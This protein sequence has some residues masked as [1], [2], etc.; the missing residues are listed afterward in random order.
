MPA[1]Y[2]DILGVSRN[3]T[4]KEIRSAFLRLAREFHPDKQ[5][6]RKPGKKIT[7]DEFKGV[8]D[9][10]ETLHDPSK[11]FMYDVLGNTSPVLTDPEDLRVVQT[12]C[13]CCCCFTGFYLILALL[14]WTHVLNVSWFILF[15]PA[16]LFDGLVLLPLCY[17]VLSSR[18]DTWHDYVPLLD[19]LAF[20]A[21][22]VLLYTQLTGYTHSWVMAAGPWILIRTAHSLGITRLPTVEHTKLFQSGASLPGVW[23]Y[24]E[25]FVKATWLPGFLLASAMMLDGK[26]P[27]AEW[28]QIWLVPWVRWA[29][30]W[31]AAGALVGGGGGAKDAGCGGF[32][33]STG[34]FGAWVSLY[35]CFAGPF[36][37]HVA[38]LSLIA[39]MSLST[40][41]QPSHRRDYTEVPQAGPTPPGGSAARSS[42]AMPS[43]AR[44]GQQYSAAAARSQSMV[45]RASSEE[46]IEYV[47]LDMPY[48]RP[49]PA[50]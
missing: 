12:A 49:S 35:F 26:L 4:Q 13:C 48:P 27:G 23:G 28:W 47:S 7:G 43:P 5:I 42:T 8:R 30:L 17:A 37:W 50:T 3:A 38:L 21:T 22:T 2:Y 32:C 39:F 1:D 15:I 14:R 18:V 10:Y 29:V 45:S 11:R 44:P 20:I 6:A 9:A 24:V 19:M 46:R 36:S 34:Q 16:W 31:I 40:C 33:S 25:S 41:A